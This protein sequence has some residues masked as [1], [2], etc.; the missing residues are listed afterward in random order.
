[1]AS[2]AP[3]VKVL[4][5]DQTEEDVKN[6]ENALSMEAINHLKTV[7][8]NVGND[9]MVVAPV[10]AV[11]LYTEERYQKELSHAADEPKFVNFR[12]GDGQ[13]G[14]VFLV[15]AAQSTLDIF[16]LQKTKDA[17]A[18]EPKARNIYQDAKFRK[19]TLVSA[20]D[21][22]CF[23]IGDTYA[24]A[25]YFTDPFQPGQETTGAARMFLTP[26]GGLAITVWY[27]PTKP[28]LSLNRRSGVFR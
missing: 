5:P 25:G 16:K 24:G 27:H 23:V 17:K 4:W 14:M 18:Y 19:N 8:L 1:M 28:V 13:I 20:D 3:S 12:S 2:A 11:G 15:T 10:K 6:A 7:G 21:I 9:A 26:L 22:N